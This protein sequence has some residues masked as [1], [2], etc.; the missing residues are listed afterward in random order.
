M[1]PVVGDCLVLEGKTGHGR[2][3]LQRHG[4]N[5]CILAMSTYVPHDLRQGEWI[6][7]GP[8]KD[9]SFS[10]WILINQDYHIGIVKHA[11]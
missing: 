2:Q 8:I 9:N 3:L 10:L 6:Q 5:W 4:D 11:H 7:I 1:L